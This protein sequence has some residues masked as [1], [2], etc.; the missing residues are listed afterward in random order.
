M[1]AAGMAFPES[2]DGR[3]VVPAAAAGCWLL[4]AAGCWLLATGWLR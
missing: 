2:H 4:M 3:S 1:T